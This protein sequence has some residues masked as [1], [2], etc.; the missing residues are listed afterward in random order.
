MFSQRESY[1]ALLA[2]SEEKLAKVGRKEELVL[3]NEWTNEVSNY[4]IRTDRGNRFVHRKHSP[5]LNLGRN[6]VGAVIL[7]S[8]HL[9]V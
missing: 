6:K 7:N 8:K 2:E 1:E 4:G 5:I 3:Y 9:T